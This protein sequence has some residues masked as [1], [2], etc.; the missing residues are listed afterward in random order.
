MASYFS[1]RAAA[2]RV[3]MAKLSPHYSVQAA[4]RAARYERLLKEAAPLRFSDP[5]RAARLCEQAYRLA[6]RMNYAYGAADAL[7]LKSLCDFALSRYEEAFREMQ[8]AIRMYG[9]AGGENRVHEMEYNLGYFHA[10]LG[11]YATAIETYLRSLAGTTNPRFRVIILS[12]L[13]RTLAAFGDPRRGLA[14]GSRALQAQFIEASRN[15]AD[16]SFDLVHLGLG[17]IRFRLGEHDESLRHF[18]EALDAA[19]DRENTR[20]MGMALAGI[21]RLYL[22]EREP[23]A[24]AVHLRRGLE[25]HR[26]IAYKPGVGE[27][28]RSLGMAELQR[29]NLPEAVRLLRKSLA[30]A[31]ELRLRVLAGE[32]HEGLAIAH[33]QQGD[34]AG[35]L[36]HM[37]RAGECRHIL[38]PNDGVGRV[39][40]ALARYELLLSEA[41]SGVP[42]ARERL[43]AGVVEAKE[44][45]LARVNVRL[46]AAEALL[47]S[48]ERDLKR[49]GDDPKLRTMLLRRVRAH[50]ESRA[51]SGPDLNEAFATGF[52]RRLLERHPDLTP[53]EIRV[54]GLL[55]LNLS[56][57]EIAGMMNVSPHNIDMHRWRIRK[58]IALESGRTLVAYLGTMEE[59]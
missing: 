41:G 33:K 26:A 49:S 39:A 9:A 3:L 1:R 28:S 7:S 2:G 15:S 14:I 36:E 22:M 18:Q 20:R 40:D 25:L 11:D 29:G 21:G 56:T 12:E 42:G 37:E 35:A 59:G 8:E 19:S 52:S 50:Q 30:I 5:A 46:S 24:A 6:L 47:D 43:L 17:E 27:L 45:E 4:E 23:A 53:T 16:A 58:K 54:C 32:S 55:R 57:K 34:A 31:E 48:I 10:T 13:G 51:A 38:L 44:G